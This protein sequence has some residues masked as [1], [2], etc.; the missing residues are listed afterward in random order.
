MDIEFLKFPIGE[1]VINIANNLVNNNYIDENFNHIMKYF[2]QQFIIILNNIEKSKNKNFSIREN[3]LS[4]AYFKDLESF[5]KNEKLK[6]IRLIEKDKENLLN[7]S[8][9]M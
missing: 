6:I 1:S 2:R 8:I 9:L 7:F 3:A 5:F 4:E